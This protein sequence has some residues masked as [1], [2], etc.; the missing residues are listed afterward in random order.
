MSH[1]KILPS[2]LFI[3]HLWFAW[4]RWVL[5]SR[6]L[7]WLLP[8]QK[9]EELF[10]CSNVPLSLLN[11]IQ[12]EFGS[13][14]LHFRLW[15]FHRVLLLTLSSSC[16]IGWKHHQYSFGLVLVLVFLPVNIIW[17]VFSPILVGSKTFG[18]A[19]QWHTRLEDLLQTCRLW[20][21]IG[22][23]HVLGGTVFLC[24]HPLGICPRCN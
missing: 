11:I 22:L 16:C 4:T 12:F 8:Q 2:R 19:F 17:L 1:I 6:H 5:V 7:I 24:K 20:V 10:Q 9:Y 14:Y 13:F 23:V 21:Q 18:R 15:L 3:K